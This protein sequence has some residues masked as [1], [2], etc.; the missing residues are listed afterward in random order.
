MDCI[1]CKIINQEI[2]SHKVY[3]DESVY[4]FLD[5]NPSTKGHTVVIPKKHLET[6]M[7]LPDND[8]NNL[9]LAVKKISQHLEKTLE[10]AGLNIGINM[11]KYAGQVVDHLH[12]HILPRFE[13]DNG[14][15]IHSIVNNPPE[16]DLK[17][18]L[19]K[20]KVD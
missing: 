11:R 13:G 15:S 4:A 18:I 5:I 6:L 14:G 10:P 16:E 7:D 20:I 9:F 17:D 1:F 19:E 12:I 3:E 2:P 8:V